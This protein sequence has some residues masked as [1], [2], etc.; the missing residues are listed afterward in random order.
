ML[1]PRGHNCW[2]EEQLGYLPAHLRARARHR[3]DERERKILR[4]LADQGHPL[5]PLPKS[6]WRGP[7]ANVAHRDANTELR[8][9]V[10]TVGRTD[11]REESSHKP[12][13]TRVEHLPASLQRH[14]LRWL[15]QFE[16][17]AEQHLRSEHRNS[18]IA[19]WLD[20]IVD[21]EAPRRSHQELNG[22]TEIASG[23]PMSWVEYGL[24]ALDS[25]IRRA[26]KNLASRTMTFTAV[27]GMQ[28]AL[29]M[30]SD[31]LGFPIPGQDMHAA[32]GRA[33]DPRWWKQCLRKEI[34]WRREAIWAR[35]R[36]TQIA[37][38]SPDGLRE[39]R[40]TQQAQ[41][42][43]AAKHQMEDDSGNKVG[44][45]TL[46]EG[47]DRRRYAEL[48]A[49]TSGMADVA[50]TEG[51][52]PRLITLTCPSR[53]HPTTCAGGYHPRANCLYDGTTVK[54]AHEWSMR[55]W[56]LFRAALG[57]R[58]IRTYWAIGVQPHYDGTPHYHIVLWAAPDHWPEIER[59]A[60]KYWWHSEPDAHAQP[61]SRID[62]RTLYGGHSGVVA[63]LARVICYVARQ[64]DG[65][66]ENEAES[67]SAWAAAHGIR[68][69]RTSESH[70]TVWR[71]LRRR[72]ISATSLGPSAVAA[73]N[74]ARGEPVAG[75]KPDYAAFLKHR[76]SADLRPAYR[77]DENR[78]GERV[79]RVVGIKA[80]D[81]GN[82][83]APTTLW[84]LKPKQVPPKPAR[85]TVMPYGPRGAQS[86]PKAGGETAAEALDRLMTLAP[87][88]GP[89]A[90]IT[91]TRRF[92]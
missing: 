67:A 25:D 4:D 1:I 69:Y 8:V 10:D 33:T 20:L 56:Q 61:K 70:V 23:G 86:A 66:G 42:E 64:V 38:I 85:Y 41:Q 21:T 51:K 47:R 80:G 77:D 31:L 15:K 82:P 84:T 87:T 58:G 83:L 27:L 53:M 54:Q 79:P 63:Y 48:I 13:P 34:R 22:L 62:I 90:M 5:H 46:L 81:D 30:Q 76:S 32:W 18:L 37:Y 74:A 36:P 55:N 16:Y 40:S 72:D 92:G 49:R 26:A 68:R 43:W 24:A 88:T 17:R 7:R 91:S 89:P 3:R 65:H 29:S 52:T 39:Y 19:P 59:L 12:Y 50:Q 71:Y 73:Q 60:L 9:L 2:V 44:L 14:A 75:V 11:P 78:F 6:G 35:L 28:S 57:N 45:D